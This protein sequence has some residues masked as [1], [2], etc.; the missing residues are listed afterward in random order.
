MHNLWVGVL[1]PIDR[2]APPLYTEKLV[3][4]CLGASSIQEGPDMQRKLI[5]AVAVA[6]AM[7]GMESPA[8]ASLIDITTPGNLLA[9]LPSSDLAASTIGGQGFTGGITDT[10]DNKA[11]TS[12]QDDGLIFQDSDTDQRFVVTGFNSSI[13]EIRFFSSPNDLGRL[14]PSLTI[15]YSK[16]STLSINSGDSNYTGPAGGLLVPTIAL[17]PA[18]LNH[19]VP[20]STNA[21]ID[22]FVDAPVGTQTLLFDVGNANGEG[23]RIDEVQAFPTPEPGTLPILGILTALA[24]LTTKG[25]ASRRPC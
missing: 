21:Y 2:A 15:Y 4:R 8:R 10:V 23:D 9:L 13:G 12:T 25:R 3:L 16:N 5:F 18:A 6:G 24:L 11:G 17:T 19:P 22:L 7:L 1:D 14:P 20:G